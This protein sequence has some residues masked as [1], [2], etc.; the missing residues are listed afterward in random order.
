MLSRE[1]FDGSGEDALTKAT[2]VIG[3][4]KTATLPDGG[5]GAALAGQHRLLRRRQATTC[6]R[7]SRSRSTCRRAAC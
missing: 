5:D 7:S 3:A 6:C 4:A 1:V 2:A